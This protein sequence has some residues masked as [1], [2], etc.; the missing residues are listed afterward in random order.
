[1]GCGAEEELRTGKFSSEPTL[2]PDV[3]W[4]ASRGKRRLG[5]ALEVRDDQP[6]ITREA[7]LALLR[8]AVSGTLDPGIERQWIMAAREAGAGWGQ[9][10]E[11]L[12]WDPRRKPPGSEWVS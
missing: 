3:A 12:N 11:A 6:K 7:A 10:E 9:I 4:W 5:E 2:R 8:E 1:L